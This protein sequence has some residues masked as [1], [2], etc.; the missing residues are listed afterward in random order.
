MTGYKKPTA[1]ELAELQNAAHRL[2]IDSIESTTVAGSGHPTSCASAAE[3]MSVLFKRVMKYHVQD[4][5][6][7]SNDRFVLSKGHAA[8]VLY[9]AWKEVG[10]LK[11]DLNNLRKFTSDLEGHPPVTL[12]FVDVATGSLGQGLSNAA[13]MAWAAKNVDKANYRVYCMMGDGEC[14]EGSVWEAMQYSSHYKLDNLCA[15]IDCN[16]LGQS[17]ATAL[18]HD[19]EVYRKR[20]E[21]F[22][23]NTI[24]IDGHDVAAIA[25]AFAEA[26]QTKDVPTLIVAQ[27]YK[28]KHMPEQENMDNWHGKPMKK[29]VFEKIK[30]HLEGLKQETNGAKVEPQ[31]PD[32]KVDNLTFEGGL[33]L[34]SPPNYQKSDKIATRAAY[35]TALKKMGEA[36]E[37]VCGFDGDTKNSTFSLKFAEAFPERFSECFIAEQNLAGVAIGAACRNRS[38]TF[39]STFAAFFSRAAD[40]IRMGA[41]SKTNANFCGSHAGISIGEDGPSQMALEDVS[42]FRSIPGSTVFYPSDAVSCERAVEYAANTEGVCFIRTSRPATTQVYENNHN[43]E[44][45]KAN[46]IKEGNSVAVFGCGITLH[47]ALE[48]AEILAKE[49]INISVIDPFTV[50]PMDPAAVKKAVE[51]SGGK[52]LTVE[53]HYAHGGLH[54]AVAEVVCEHGLGAKVSPLAVPGVA[55][56][57]KAAELMAWAKIDATGIVSAVKNML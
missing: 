12:P 48:A 26:E 51:L 10:F 20:G 33:K 30:T 13:G 18:G 37:R 29:D 38:V 22:G 40:Q 16:R 34:S 53:D 41:I 32:C 14:A 9:A 54:S 55:R 28:G 8:P 6:N 19:M 27:T 15:I 4:P 17:E 44:I 56:S 5:G 46:F 31:Q 11:E 50:K 35:G 7:A 39:A 24:V 25:K 42:F 3:V 57:G 21:A 1:D 52:L 45:G 47:N 49:N 2:R 43:F 36:N 23:W